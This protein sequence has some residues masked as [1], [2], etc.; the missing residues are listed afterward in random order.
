MCCSSRQALKKL[1]TVPSICNF[2][3]HSIATSLFSPW[4]V[5]NVG[6]KRMGREQP[7]WSAVPSLDDCAWA[8]R[9]FLSCLNGSPLKTAVRVPWSKIIVVGPCLWSPLVKHYFPPR[10]PVRLLWQ[11]CPWSKTQWNESESE[12]MVWNE[13]DSRESLSHLCYSTLL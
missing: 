2:Y 6:L 7:Q 3:S 8:V 11:I 12:Y 9:K 4:L 5:L 10:L 13:T 1:C